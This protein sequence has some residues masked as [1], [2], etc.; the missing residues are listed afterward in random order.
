MQRKLKMRGEKENTA[1]GGLTN[2]TSREREV[3]NETNYRAEEK[4]KGERERG[5]AEKTPP[6]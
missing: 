6:P 4:E 2:G 3:A 5:G 1:G